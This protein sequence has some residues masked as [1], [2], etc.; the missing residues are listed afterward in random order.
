MS[1]HKNSLKVKITHKIPCLLNL[2]GGC[3]GF[4]AAKSTAVSRYLPGWTSTL[5]TSQSKGSVLVYQAVEYT[6]HVVLLA[7]ADVARPVRS[8]S[9]MSNNVAHRP[10]DPNLL[11]SPSC[12]TNT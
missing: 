4:L 9:E 11:N 8:G 2:T 10:I 5:Q 7:A 12:S 3:L 6:H 1:Q